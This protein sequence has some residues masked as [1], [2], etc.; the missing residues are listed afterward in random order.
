MNQGY[1]PQNENKNA[2]SP[3]PTPEPTVLETL[4]AEIDRL[5][6]RIAHLLQL[7][8]KTHPLILQLPKGDLVELAYPS[9]GPF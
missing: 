6:M 7:R 8:E 5:N 4:N 3:V 2:C 9:S 1:T